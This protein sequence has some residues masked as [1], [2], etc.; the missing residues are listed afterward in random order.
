[1]IPTPWVARES[2][3]VAAARGQL[4]APPDGKELP[5][6]PLPK[7]DAGKVAERSDARRQAQKELERKTATKVE[8]TFGNQAAS[9]F[10][11][12]G[13]KFGQPNKPF[14]PQNPPARTPASAV[15]AAAKAPPPAPDRTEIRGDNRDLAD[16]IRKK[17]QGG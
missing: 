6:E 7:V 5:W 8:S 10:A 1:L 16:A 12:G 15:A 9:P 3:Y 17:L 14:G 11:G 2:R 13:T 4:Q